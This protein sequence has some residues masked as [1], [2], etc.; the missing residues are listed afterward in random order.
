M[1]KPAKAHKKDTAVGRR[2]AASKSPPGG[3][4][5]PV[6]TR[7]SLQSKSGQA[8]S[9]VIHELQ[10]HQI[11]LERQNEEL[12]NAHVALETLQ[13]RYFDSAPVGYLTIN[14]KGLNVQANLRF[15]SMVG[16][17]RAEVIKLPFSHFIFNEDHDIYYLLC[18][19]LTR[20]GQ[21][22]SCELRMVKKDGTQF[23][24]HLTVAASQNSAGAPELL[25]VLSDVTLR[26]QSEL[27][28]HESEERYRRIVQTAEE[29]V[30]SIDVRSL[31]D[32]V[33]PKMAQMMGY[34]AAEM[35]GRPIDDFL[36]D[37]GR[38]LLVQHLKRRKGGIA[39]QFEFK[40]VRK[41]GSYLWAFV[42]TNAITN[43]AGV[44][45]GAI[46][47]LTDISAR[48]A[49]EAAMRES[50]ARLRAIF[51]QA[52]VGVGI[53]D[54][55]TGRF[56]D[57]NHRY[58]TITGRTREQLLNC[59][60][61]QITHP[62]DRAE[63]LRLR[64]QLKAGK[65]QEYTLEKRYLRPDGTIVWGNVHAT[66]I[67]AISGQSEQHLAV[68]EDITERKNAEAKYQRER[69]L[70]E[71]LVNHTSAI[72]ILLDHEGL[73]VH[74]NEPTLKM[75]GYRQAELVGQT[76]P[77][78]AGFMDLAET[79]RAKERLAKLLTGTDIPS[80]EVTLR[81]K[82][83]T[84]HVVAVSSIITRTPTGAID[85]IVVT[86]AD[87]TERNRLQQELIRI[88]EQEQA[89]IGHNLHDG[90]GQTM[91]G[92]ASLM[93]ALESELSGAQ[94]TS[95]GRIRKLLQD[96]IQEVRRMSH[97]L[98]PAAVKNRG[99]GG[100]LQLLAETIR[101]N[102]R[103][104]C[105]CEIDP[106]IRLEDPEKETHIFRIAQEAANNALRHG[107][108]KQLKLSLQRTSD[109]DCELTV[110]DNGTGFSRKAGDGIGMRVMD[111]R[112]NLI[113]GTLQTTSKPRK[114]VTVTC[115]FPCAATTT[116]PPRSKPKCSN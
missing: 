37:E 85:R 27:A 98:S 67:A 30:W 109:Q 65:I 93:E 14:K 36:D 45:V 39:E 53:L 7:R 20:T 94:R 34:T 110:A 77:W 48:R 66:R 90:V 56:L 73:I 111:Y 3:T 72:I 35:I 24:A 2:R 71:T 62:D 29:G 83:G 52:S 22:Q 102:H 87:L 58:C 1:K 116:K 88:S 108:P 15:A 95:A 70:N 80:R 101:T 100:V 84:A 78:D 57:V 75:L 43:A 55:R 50:E 21:P 13:A 68:V 89:R 32:Y 81:G 17:A 59:T 10:V 5:A 23:W 82:D 112:A 107:N 38:A 40:Y 49:N 4:A 91:T 19:E 103:T 74:V 115:R 92:V 106:D 99:L 114:G 8:L 12:R 104:S 26:K 47:L 9:V 25:V 28:L 54:G 105:T 46:A 63:N 61:G 18:M 64:N 41:D 6:K 31:T 44:Y 42:S 76:P 97:S 16:L 60:F 11:E 33:N 51:E 96:A 113:G 79:S 86:G 69:G